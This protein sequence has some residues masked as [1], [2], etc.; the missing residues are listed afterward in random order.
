M[1]TA[2]HRFGATMLAALFAL[3]APVA[4]QTKF[5]V[6][7]G[8]VDG[9]GSPVA[10]ATVVLLKDGLQ[11]SGGS[12]DADG[13]FS[14]KAAPGCYLIKVQFIGYKTVESEIEIEHTTDAGVFTLLADD[15]R[16]DDVVVTA[17]LIRREADRFV[18]DVAN[19][20]VAVGKNAEELLKTAPGVWINDDKVSI[21]GN[22]GSKIYINDREVHM[23]DAQ[24]MTYLRS[25]KSDDIQKI[26]VI[27][28][29][30][31]DYDAS[32]SGGIIKLT[33][34]R[35]TQSGLMGT[36]ATYGR[37]SSGLTS[38]SPQ[39]SLDFN[40]NKLNLYA[41]GWYTYDN[42]QTDIE[43]HTAYKNASTVIDGGSI[44]RS[45]GNNFGGSI[46]AVYEFTPRHSIGAQIDY[47]DMHRPG[48]TD[49]RTTFDDGTIRTF[50]TSRYD[51]TT[52]NRQVTATFN[53]L[54]RVDD[55]GSVLKLLADYTQNV[56][57]DSNRYFNRAATGALVKD[58]TYTAVNDSRY[59]LGTATLSFDKV[60]SP[61]V[62]L[63]TGLKYT[64]NNTSNK[65]DYMGLSANGEWIR[66]NDTS[67]DIGYTEHISAAYAIASL[68]L[69]RVSMVAGLRGE[70]TRSL[71]KDRS[72]EQ[73]YFDLFPNANLSY[74]LTADGAYSLIAQ[75]SRTISR[76][77]FWSLTPTMQKISEYMYQTGNPN[78]KASY[79]NSV[80][81][82]A[83]LKYKYT[84]SIGASFI[85]NSIQQTTVA[86]AD[87]PDI[88]TIMPIN[89]PTTDNYYV[90]VSLPFQI[91]PWW[92]FN[93][94]A[95]G[96]S[97]GQRIAEDKPLNRYFAGMYSGNM[98]FTLPADFIFELSGYMM[99]GMV[100]GNT[101]IK[102]M[103][104][105]NASV[106]KRLFDK[107]LTLAVGVNGLLNSR[108]KI[109]VEEDTFR[110]D[111]TLRNAWS[112]RQ[113]TFSV[114]YNFNA[115]KQFKKR[116]VE[117]GSLEDRG[118]LGSGSGSATGS[119][120]K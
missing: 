47:S 62:T 26:E 71:S 16:I 25:L 54:W 100:T 87:N 67:F 2:M 82:T 10:Y 45:R 109:Y 24:L 33:L 74:A 49:S 63:R 93:V 5:D 99:H 83:A 86:S 30:G 55:K 15:T 98:A 91:T 85:K 56:S 96:L 40:H 38:L 66:D 120:G 11:A 76:P 78:L 58:S 14:L 80:S 23:S 103:G 110:R 77:S 27:P 111:M 28:Q 64:L 88:L 92:Q 22:G 75:Y 73:N 17:Q 8:V 42:G 101:H 35:R 6:T 21:N 68:N 117:S 97:L 37:I 119:I 81:L 65:A 3:V 60:I 51:N 12:T 105:M 7:G 52:D 18:V 104:D 29:S 41:S 106:K 108:Q 95:M 36:V 102:S 114:T 20:P 59:R 107:R 70:Y 50:N 116:S 43:E 112:A 72:V 84:V 13:R 34:K 79:T 1:K 90:N 57:D 31:A 118:R 48:T 32:S 94:N 113:F 44:N 4:A 39:F 19:S 69:G 89:F 46:G 9:E 61:K 115:G 53:Y